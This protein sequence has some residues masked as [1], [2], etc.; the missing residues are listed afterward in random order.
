MVPKKVSKEVEVDD[1]ALLA[2]LG[3]PEDFNEKLE[4]FLKKKEKF[5]MIVGPDLYTHPNS[6]N[7]ARLVALVE[8]YTKF[9]LVMIPNLANTLGVS[10]IC[11]LDEEAGEYTIGY[12]TD[13][14][15][16]LSA[17]G[18]GDLDMPALNQQEGTF[19]SINK[20]VN[21]TNVA[22][23][24]GG[25]V[26]N[27]IANA[28]GLSA[29]YTIDY[30]KELGS[31]KGYQSESFD[32]LPNYY[33]NS[34]EEMRGYQLKRI[35]IRRS[36]NESVNELS[37][38]TFDNDIVYLSNP[39]LQ[40]TA[41]TNASHQLKDEGGLYGSEAFMNRYELS[42][43]DKVLVKTPK[44]EVTVTM[45]HDN[46]ID[47]EIAYLPTFDVNLN[48]EALFDGYRFSSASFKKV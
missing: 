35:G 9:E 3:A 11:D 36:S 37:D 4:K 7:L 16:K 47:G 44:A 40:F 39:V 12:N 31:I 29:L 32:D 28:L 18:D 42:E 8:K 10:L 20:R 48:S 23:S 5:S 34:G 22:L 21:P 38:V 1:N 43:G 25:Y 33:T 26:L 30:T 17:L 41:F 2:I 45:I 6:R 46:K 14:D 15:F 13:G 19:T 24:Y 27:D